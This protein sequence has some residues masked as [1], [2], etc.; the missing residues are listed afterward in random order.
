V[1]YYRTNTVVLLRSLHSI[2]AV[3]LPKDYK[4]K[5]EDEGGSLFLGM[6]WTD[7]KNFRQNM[8]R[9]FKMAGPNIGIMNPESDEPLLVG[10]PNKILEKNEIYFRLKLQ[11]PASFQSLY[12]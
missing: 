4:I 9:F 1:V 10:L 11:I 5:K 8:I 7:N 6:K 2:D 12:R 3:E